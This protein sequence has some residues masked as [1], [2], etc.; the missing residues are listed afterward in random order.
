PQPVSASPNPATSARPVAADRILI[1]S[2]CG[3][4]PNAVIGPKSRRYKPLQDRFRVRAARRKKRSI[5]SF[6]DRSQPRP[7]DHLDTAQPILDIPFCP[8]PE[9]HALLLAGPPRK[10]PAGRRRGQARD[11]RRQNR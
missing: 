3:A 5:A 1:V 8:P 4:V 7:Y 11:L 6:L 9:W 10:G 2:P